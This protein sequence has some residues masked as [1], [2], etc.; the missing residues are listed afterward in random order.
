MHAWNGRQRWDPETR[1]DH[2]DRLQRGS[3]FGM[4]PDKGEGEERVW[5]GQWLHP[6]SKGN[7]KQPE[8]QSM[9]QHCNVAIDSALCQ[10][11]TTSCCL[12]RRGTMAQC[13]L[14]HYCYCWAEAR[15]K[16]ARM[17]LTIKLDRN[18]SSF[19]LA[20][21]ATPLSVTDIPIAPSARMRRHCKRMLPM[22]TGN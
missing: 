1:S 10:H 6:C 12:H 21:S 15:I 2:L 8:H 17:T 16:I 11:I 9:W 13:Y 5:A 7:A 4:S 22:E 14:L 19:Q 3:D 18:W 20:N